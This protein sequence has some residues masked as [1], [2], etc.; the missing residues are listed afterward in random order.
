MKRIGMFALAMVILP[1]AAA[2]TDAAM[3]SGD[4]AGNATGHAVVA[5]PGEVIAYLTPTCGCCAGWVEHLR[6]NG[7][8]VRVVYQN[9]LTEVRRQH[10]VPLELM[11]CHT[12]VVDG[13]AFE[14]HV[15]ADVVRR[16]L[17]ERPDIRGV[18]VPGMPVGTPGMESP[19]GRIDPYDVISFDASGR[20]AVY[21]SRR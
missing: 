4:H 19:D 7:F 11:S 13:F 15:P 10:G 16:V 3:A 6:E 1:I 20:L 2:C 5:N 18:S 21:E 12:G 9:D 8:E 17:D 14:G